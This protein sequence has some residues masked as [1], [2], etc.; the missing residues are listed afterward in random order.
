MLKTFFQLVF[1]VAVGASAL[2]ALAHGTGSREISSKD[3]RAVQF[4]YSSSDPMAFVDIKVY[5]PGNLD[6]PSQIGRTDAQG[7][8][9]LVVDTPGT[10]RVTAQDHE[11]HRAELLLEAAGV[12]S[13]VSSDASLPSTGDKPAKA[14]R[15]VTATLGVSLIINL[16][17]LPAYTVLR[18]RKMRAPDA[19]QERPE[20]CTVSLW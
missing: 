2:V 4:Y 5:A 11:G 15:L 9:A 10:W 14:S 20:R 13:G 19:K 6:I 12:S 17:L 8:F 7:R 1:C 3:I 18:R 16:C